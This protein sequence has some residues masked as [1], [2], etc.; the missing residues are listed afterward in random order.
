VIAWA[1]WV[2]CPRS[3]AP[4]MGAEAPAAAAPAAAPTAPVVGPA[5]VV[6]A[7]EPHLCVTVPEGWVG[8]TS[9]GASFLSLSHPDGYRFELTVAPTTDAFPAALDGYD[10]LFEDAGTY[11]TPPLLPDAATRSWTSRDPSGS[12][13]RA[14]YGTVRG[15]A[16][17]ARIEYPLGHFTEGE[18]V[19]EPLL[20]APC[21]P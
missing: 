19:V 17:E 13:V 10:L 12:Y 3:A 21:A 14:W 5:R 11:R 8:T 1:W 15:V 16:V 18:R 20:A 7:Q 9:G 4:P 6:Q 2:G